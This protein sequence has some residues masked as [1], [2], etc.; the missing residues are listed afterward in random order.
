M[1]R[2]RD[3]AVDE[4]G[5]VTGEAHALELVRALDHAATGGDGSG[6]DELEV[7]AGGTDA[8]REDEGYVLVETDGAGGDM[9][10]AQTSGKEGKGALVFLPGEDVAVAGERTR[11]EELVCAALFERGADEEWFRFRGKDESPEAF[12]AVEMEVCEVDG[13]SGGVGEDDGVDFVF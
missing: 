10:I 3:S 13:G 5:S 9:S 2:L 11:S 7:R 4:E 12:A 6:R 8:F 1:E